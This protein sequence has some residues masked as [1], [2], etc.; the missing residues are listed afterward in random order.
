MEDLKLKKF[1]QLHER[2]DFKRPNKYKRL[3]N[4]FLMPFHTRND[5]LNAVVFLNIL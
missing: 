5:I 2:V 4:A 3:K 1:L